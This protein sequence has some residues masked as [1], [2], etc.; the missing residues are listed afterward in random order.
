MP[1]V[2]KPM[3]DNWPKYLYCRRGYFFW[4]DPVDKREYP[5]GKNEAQA[6]AQAVKLNAI[7]LQPPKAE[8][9]WPTLGDFLPTFREHLQSLEMAKNTRYVWNSNLYAIERS[10]SGVKISKRYEDAPDMTKVCSDFVNRYVAEG[11]VRAAHGMFTALS[12]MFACMAS[13]GWIAVNPVL[14]IKRTLPPVKVK[15]ERLTLDEFKRVYEVAPQVAPWLRNAMELSVVTVQ[16]RAEVQQMKFR[17]VSD[18]R[19]HV[20][21]GKTGVHIRIP[22]SL[23]IDALGWSVEDAIRR[24]KNSVLSPYLVHHIEHQGQAKPGMPVSLITIT[25]AFTEAVRLAGIK[26]EDGHTPP[27]FH[28][29]R[30]LGIRLYK[31]EGYDPQDLAGHKQSSTTDLYRDNR[32]AEWIEVKDKSA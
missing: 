28:E 3:R 17:D 6:I 13:K 2:R 26:A 31:A 25:E 24:C 5:L 30:S 22:L 21:R 18:G 1:T 7:P 27:T 12:D 32:G 19:L 15:R 16:A 20:V 9:Q 29:L 14:P 11:K 4:R 8:E 10:L 23:R